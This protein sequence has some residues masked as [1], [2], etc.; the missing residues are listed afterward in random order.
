MTSKLLYLQSFAHSFRMDL[1][2]DSHSTNSIYFVNNM[3]LSLY[4]PFVYTLV[5]AGKF[6][7]N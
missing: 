2:N 7:A 5:D 3:V 1:L 4:L 6:N